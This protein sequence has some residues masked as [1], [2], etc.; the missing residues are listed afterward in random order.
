MSSCCIRQVPSGASGGRGLNFLIFFFTSKFQDTSVIRSFTIGNAFIGSTVIGLSIGISL[1]RVMHLN[2]GN[3][4]TSAEHEPHFPP[5]QFPRQAEAPR[6]GALMAWAAS[7][8]T[9]P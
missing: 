6:S 9:I 7:G 8:P 5:L 1:M 2:F 3:P 4:L